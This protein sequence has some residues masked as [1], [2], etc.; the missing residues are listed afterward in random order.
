MRIE[1][2][3]FDQC[4]KTPHHWALSN[5]QTRMS[6]STLQTSIRYRVKQFL[7]IGAKPGDIFAICLPNDINYMIDVLAVLECQ[8]I[9]MP[10]HHE[11][12]DSELERTFSIQIPHWFISN[13]GIKKMPVKDHDLPTLEYTQSDPLLFGFTSGSTGYPKGFIK[14]H[15]SWSSVFDEWSEN[16]HLHAGDR[17]L[18]PLHLSYSAQLFAAL[19]ALCVGIEVHMVNSFS[20]E[21]FFNSKSTC[22]TITPALI[23]PLIKYHHVHPLETNKM[24]RAVISVGNTLSPTLRKS[25]E[26]AFPSSQLYEYYGSSEM[27]CVSI[28]TPEQ[29]KK[30]PDTVGFPIESVDVTIRNDIGEILPSGEIGKVFVK[31]SQAFSGFVNNSV[32]T[33]RSFYEGYVTSHDLGLMNEDGSLKII[34]RDRDIIKSGGSMIFTEEIEWLLMSIRGVEEAA[35]FGQ[36][37]ESRSEIVVAAVVLNDIS[38]RDT[39]KALNS[40]L[41]SYKKP[42]KWIVLKELPKLRSGKVDKLSLKKKIN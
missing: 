19:Q 32:E 23:Q 30:V 13:K 17:I 4:K 26:Q 42:R 14:S 31:T 11:L 18:I 1:Q 2:R 36:L 15:D 21:S 24:P 10:L 37:D 22:V 6:F 40:K 39:K 28:L 16:F 5:D 20:P 29:A 34:G 38:L 12:S 3:I 33:D 7:N 25:F 41:A 35:V 27:G 8:G 9:I